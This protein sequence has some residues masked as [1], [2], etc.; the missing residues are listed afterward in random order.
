VHG[1]TNPA[2]TMTVNYQSIMSYRYQFTNLVT[3]VGSEV[4]PDY[5]HEKLSDLEEQHLSE[6]THVHDLT[7]PDLGPPYWLRFEHYEPTPETGDTG[8]VHEIVLYDMEYDATTPYI[9]IDW[10]QDNAITGSATVRADIDGNHRDDDSMEGRNDWAELTLLMTCNPNSWMLSGSPDAMAGDD[11]LDE[12]TA[13]DLGVLYPEL[14]A[15]VDVG[16]ACSTDLVAADG[17][18]KVQLVVLGAAGLDLTYIDP[19]T[20]R[21]RHVRP[22]VSSI[23][24]VDGDSIL[25]LLL[26]VDPSGLP[27]LGSG[28]T[29]GFQARQPN[30]RVVLGE[31]PISWTSSTT[32][33][34]ADGVRDSCDLCPAQPATP[35]D[36]D[37]CP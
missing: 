12:Q 16:P 1:G 28:D 6:T 13:A 22:E 32:D 29:L 20:M 14:I 2:Q 35:P 19:S 5:S 3:V 23:E 30:G 7:E 8:L 34:D 15:T 17:S 33:A 36:A 37:G 4:V 9:G 31:A 25:D 24:D 10:D 21:V 18:G 26:Q 27:N 11:E